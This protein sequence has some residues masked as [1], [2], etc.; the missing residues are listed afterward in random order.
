MAGNTGIGCVSTSISAS[1]LK[2]PDKKLVLERLRYM[3]YF[4]ATLPVP[5]LL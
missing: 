3:A 4:K 2:I 1:S 5:N